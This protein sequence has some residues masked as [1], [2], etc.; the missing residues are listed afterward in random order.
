MTSSF[1]RKSKPARALPRGAR[2]S[3]QQ[4]FLL[5]SSGVSSLDY[6]LGGGILVGTVLLVE[7]DKEGSYA[8]VVLKYFLAEGLAQSNAL[9]IA[10]A[11][12]PPAQ[13]LSEIPRVDE[14]REAAPK[15]KKDGDGA[16]TDAMQIAW[17]YQNS[18]TV[19]TEV[20]ASTTAPSNPTAPPYCLRFDLSQHVAPEQ[21]QA[22]SIAQMHMQARANPPENMYAALRRGLSEAIA[23]FRLA[24]TPGTRAMESLLRIV[25][26]SL[27]SPAWSPGWTDSKHLL[28]FLHGLRGLVRTSSAAAVITMPTHLL[29]PD[30]AASVRAMCDTVVALH[31][32]SAS[33][34]KHPAF[35]DY[36]GVFKIVQ[37]PR[38]NGLVPAAPV[39]FADL[40]F[41]L[42][43]TAFLIETLHLPP[44]EGEEVSRS[45]HAPTHT[46]G[47]GSLCQP[48]PTKQ[49]PLDF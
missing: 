22:A 36:H 12:R 45:T 29:P 44:E 48:N 33:V 35:K 20:G 38:L 41:K 42:R 19:Q 32:F 49:N 30:V 4:G 13:I 9:F 47:S 43:R 26:P 1:V 25:L 6:L 15:E 23:P 14:S 21:L 16:S 40:V 24:P 17:R 46:H 27:G 18:A 2:A 10:S 28:G 7:E 31:A 3:T 8:D 37:L 11:D 39:E 34:A 5:V